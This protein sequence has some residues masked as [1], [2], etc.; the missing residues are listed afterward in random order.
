VRN[1]TVPALEIDDSKDQSHSLSE[2]DEVRLDE[3]EIPNNGCAI[4]VRKILTRQEGNMSGY[5]KEVCY[6]FLEVLKQMLLQRWR[7]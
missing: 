3:P 4:E 5:L 2:L 7:R 1:R 6:F